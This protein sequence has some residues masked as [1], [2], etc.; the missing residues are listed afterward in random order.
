MAEDLGWKLIEF[1]LVVGFI[2]EPLPIT[3]QNSSEYK[4]DNF[5]IVIR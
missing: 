3:I 4:F 1:N 5:V 2:F